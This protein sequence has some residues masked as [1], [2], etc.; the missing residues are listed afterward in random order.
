MMK[1]NR[2]SQFSRR[3]ILSGIG[4][5]IG[6]AA[7]PI[8]TSGRGV[9]ESPSGWT[10][11]WDAAVMRAQIAGY[12]RSYD[13]ETHSIRGERGAEYN[14]Q[15]NVRNRTVHL[16]R[17][18]LEY[19]SLLLYVDDSASIERATDLIRTVLQ[20]Q[21]MDPASRYFG[22][23]GWYFEEPPEQMHAAD[24]NWADFNGSTLLNILLEHERKL[25]AEVA[26]SCRES[27]RAC[28]VSI[29]KR[30]VGLDYTNIA[31]MGTYVTLATAELFAD[32]DLLAYAKDRAVR[33]E[34]TIGVSGSFSEYNSPTYLA[35]TIGNI[36][37][38]LKYVKDGPS[39]AIAARLNALAWKHVA[40]HWHAQTMQLA[41]P[42]SRA[43][44][45][46][47]GSPMWIQKATGNRVKVLSLA[48]LA[49]HDSGGE[50]TIATVDWLCPEELIPLFTSARTHQHREI[51]TAGKTADSKP[52]LLLDGPKPAGATVP[53]EGTT[54]L[55]PNFALGSVT[56]SDCWVQ[57]RNLIA[58]WGG[59]ARPP[60]CLQLRVLK[61]DYDFTSAL[62]YSVQDKGSVLGSIRFRP[63]G[64][65]KHPNLDPIQNGT[66]SLS[67]MRLQILF[68]NWNASNV[69]RVDGRLTTGPFVTSSTSRVAIDMG[70]VK[71]LFQS[72]NARFLEPARHLTFAFD[73]KDAL[74]TLELMEE[75]QAKMVRLVDLIDP[76]CDFALQLDDSG[77]SLE[78]L[79]TRFA[80]TI[81]SDGTSGGL[82]QLSW[83][84]G[85]HTLSVTT[86][87]A[88]LPTKKLE[89]SYEPAVDGRPYPFVRLSDT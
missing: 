81:F 45:N 75:N 68:G 63:D 18:S 48:D 30:N 42:M 4:L 34:A 31:F 5:G 35:V 28:A 59:P 16:T 76:G 62:F 36:S 83:K 50:A 52:L 12:A 54:W 41:G 2:P 7:L 17:N 29:R 53:V 88:V 87:T 89:Q 71:F 11:D 14:Y 15:S 1:C 26:T 40:E 57:R 37:R 43:Y 22:L 46:D 27:L 49:T 9:P 21:V 24:F 73:G 66:I 58:Y 80:K 86:A 67:R 3:T 44:S 61:D 32:A 84:P 69:I 8:A 65:D 78:D 39:R 85:Q 60:H 74:L 82:R 23:W 70:S 55:T 13:A 79:D 10:A 19:A 6:A 33:L 51:F 77:A 20:N 47:I 38:M 25:P 64:G 56:R 72:R